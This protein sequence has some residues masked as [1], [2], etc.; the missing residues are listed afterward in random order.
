MAERI[1]PAKKKGHTYGIHDEKCTTVRKI[2]IYP[3]TRKKPS[4]KFGSMA[5]FK[6]LTYLATFKFTLLNKE[7]FFY[8]RLHKSSL[9]FGFQFI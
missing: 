9:G 3:Y 7:N 4:H 5:F 2:F 8:V 1:Y 6:F